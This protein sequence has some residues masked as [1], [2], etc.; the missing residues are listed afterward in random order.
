ME[1]DFQPMNHLKMAHEP[2]TALFCM[3]SISPGPRPNT[4]NLAAICWVMALLALTTTPLTFR[5]SQPKYLRKPSPCGAYFLILSFRGIASRFAEVLYGTC[6][7]KTMALPSFFAQSPG[8]NNWSFSWDTTL[9]LFSTTYPS[10]RIL[11]FTTSISMLWRRMRIWV[12]D[13]QF[14]RI[15]NI[16]SAPSSHAQQ[17]EIDFPLPW[18]KLL[19]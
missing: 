11:F 13:R 6:A 15:W 1:G 3:R 12:V 8:L 4:D 18:T 9:G 14:L 10:F 2:S 7:S 19:P 16:V 5:S 17:D